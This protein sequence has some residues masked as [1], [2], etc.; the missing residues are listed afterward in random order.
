MF[1]K[2]G[3]M[4]ESDQVLQSKKCKQANH[5]GIY[6]LDDRELHKSFH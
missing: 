3:I 1:K 6:H 2:C 5:W 4:L